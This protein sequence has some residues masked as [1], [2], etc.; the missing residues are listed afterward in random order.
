MLKESRPGGWEGSS[1]L[2]NIRK[3]V[4]GNHHFIIMTKLFAVTDGLQSSNA[5]LYPSQVPEEI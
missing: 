5:R 2:E 3:G 4:I 1:L